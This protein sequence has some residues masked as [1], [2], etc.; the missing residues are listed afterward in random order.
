MLHLLLFYLLVLELVRVIALHKHDA[1]PLRHNQ[2]S[3]VLTLLQG[4]DLLDVVVQSQLSDVF[5]VLVSSDRIDSQ[6]TVLACT[7]DC[8]G[9]ERRLLTRQD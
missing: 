5:D 6:L 8:A 2:E 9:N 7:E 1:G 4:Q 3:S